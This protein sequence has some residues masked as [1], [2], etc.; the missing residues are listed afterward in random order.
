[1]S[2]KRLIS[3]VILFPIFALIIIF[4]NKYVIDVFVSV[5][6]IMSLHEFYKA[7][8]GKA[9]P[10][11]WV[12]Y[13]AAASIAF[14]HI[15]PTNRILITIGAILPTAILILFARVILSNMKFNV[16]DIAITFLGICYI[17]LFLMF[18]PIIRENLPN[19][20]ILIWFVF[21]AA[22]G[23]DIFAYLVGKNLGKHK[24]TDISPNKSIEGCIGGLLGA[25]IVVLG[26]TMLCNNVWNLN[27]SYGY[28]T[29]IAV[30]L[31][32]AGQIGDLAAS[33]VKRYCNIKDYSNLIPGHGGMLDRIDSVI[34]VLPFA[35]FLLMLI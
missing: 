26:Y 8:K 11:S 29:I 17:V 13:I 18:A 3:G 4:G 7:F 24:F 25:I 1:M 23:T 15:I 5:I 32:C 6:A 31:S 30:L 27:I 2:I 9:N 20:N 34:F 22:W 19:G 33:S 28:A 21:L 14:I 10:I 12:G 35:Y 16:I